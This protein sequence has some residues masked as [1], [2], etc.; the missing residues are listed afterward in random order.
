MYSGYSGA[1]HL[2]LRLLRKILA[3]ESLTFKYQKK[4]MDQFQISILA[5]LETRE[6]CCLYLECAISIILIDL[7]E[8]K[9]DFSWSTSNHWWKGF[10]IDLIQTTDT[11]AYSFLL[12]SKGHLESIQFGHDQSFHQILKCI[13]SLSFPFF[14]IQ[15]I[16]VLLIYWDRWSKQKNIISCGYF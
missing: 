7:L 1:R 2:Q 5:S 10:L 9:N 11:S 12:L 8:V 6:L 15:S 16:T 4:I 13:L 14:K 3:I